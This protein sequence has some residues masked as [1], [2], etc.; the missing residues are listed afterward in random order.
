MNI[1]LIGY[2]CT[3]KT[4]VGRK[5][6][7]RFRIPFYDTDEL[8]KK[9]TGRTI[10]EIVQQGGWESFR[11]EEK[12][13]I[14]GLSPSADAVIAAGGGAVMDPENREALRGNGLF[15][16]LIAD[17][18]TIVERMKKDKAGGEQRPPLCSDGMERETSEILQQ[19]TPI[20]RQL[21]HFTIDTSGKE[22]DTIADEVCALLARQNPRLGWKGLR[23]TRT[24]CPG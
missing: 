7:E 19:R 2:R 22:I 1:I 13:M 3:G 8:V 10:R 16:W 17:A 21:A 20:Y 9:H 14:R 24:P 15:L 5:I 23:M 12:A 18:H 11:Q 4:S 6:S